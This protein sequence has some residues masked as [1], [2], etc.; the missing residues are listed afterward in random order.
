MKKQVM[1]VIVV[2]M[3]MGLI[4]VE[5]VVMVHAAMTPAEKRK[6]ALAEAMK[7]NR[8]AVVVALGQTVQARIAQPDRAAFWTDLFGRLGLIEGRR[9]ASKLNN[10]VESAVENF[11][12]DPDALRSLLREKPEPVPEP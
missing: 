12:V 4:T 3:V 8:H 7:R 1:A 5:R 2:V 11:D 10:F 9:D 6:E